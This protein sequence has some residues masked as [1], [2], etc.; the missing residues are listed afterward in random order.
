MERPGSDRSRKPHRHQDKRRD[1]R[2]LHRQKAAFRQRLHRTATAHSSIRALSSARSKSRNWI[3]PRRTSPR[4]Q[5]WNSRRRPVLSPSLTAATSQVGERGPA[6]RPTGTWKTESSPAACRGA[7]VFYFPSGETT[8]TSICG[9]RRGSRTTP[10]PNSGF[11]TPKPANGGIGDPQARLQDR[12]PGT[13]G[14]QKNRTGSICAVGMKGRPHH[15]QRFWPTRSCRPAGRVV[16]PRSDRERKPHR[17]PG[18]RQARELPLE[19]TR[20]LSQ[21]VPHIAFE[22]NRDRPPVEIRRVEIKEFAAAKR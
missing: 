15:S 17:H 2:R 1:H 9:S 5:A 3:R 8:R 12:D 21:R 22:Q 19:S 6:S 11:R 4:N 18:Q 14:C 13:A 7:R 10:V 20:H 16:H